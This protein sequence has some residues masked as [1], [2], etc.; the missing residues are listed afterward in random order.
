MLKTPFIAALGAYNSKTAWQ[1][2]A[3]FK[4]NSVSRVQSHLKFSKMFKVAQNPTYSIVLNFA[5]ICALRLSNG[6]N[7]TEKSPCRFWITTPKNVIKVVFGRS[8]C[9]YGNLS[10]Y[11]NDNVFTNDWAVFWFHDCSNKW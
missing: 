9:C 7:I 2:L 10:C 4:K 11:E 6:D 8:Y 3:K 5:K 1:F